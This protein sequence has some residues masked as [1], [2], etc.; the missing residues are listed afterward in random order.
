MKAAL[1]GPDLQAGE[2]EAKEGERQQHRQVPKSA[3]GIEKQ[4]GKAEPARAHPPG[5]QIEPEQK[6]RKEIVNKRYIRKRQGVWAP[7][8]LLVH[9]GIQRR[10]G[11][12]VYT[13]AFRYLVLPARSLRTSKEA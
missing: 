5:K 2:S 12:T 10:P 3:P 9:W 13:E 11:S 8:R 1:A 6:Q 4:A 7:F